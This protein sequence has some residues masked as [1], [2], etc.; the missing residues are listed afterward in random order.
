M[1]AERIDTRSRL[2]TIWVFVMLNMIFADV[3]SFMT[4]GVLQQIMSGHAEQIVIT[5]SLL[6]VFAIVTEIPIAMVLLSKTLPQRAARWA[7]VIAAAFTAVYVVGMGSASPHYIF[8]AGVEVLGCALVAWTAWAWRTSGTVA[9]AEAD[10]P[11]R[12]L[13]AE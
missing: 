10:T 6:L 3:L 2:S 9:A 1:S 12:G 7:N 13:V 4:P 5:P 8:I 11:G